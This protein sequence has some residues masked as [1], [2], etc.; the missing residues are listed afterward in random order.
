VTEDAV[1]RMRAKVDVSDRGRKLNV[2]DVQLLTND[3]AWDRPPGVLWI[4][5]GGTEL[6]NGGAARLKGL[7]SK[8]PGR[9][10]VHVKTQTAE[11]PKVVR[12]TGYTVDKSDG[13]LHAE[14]KEWLGAGAVREE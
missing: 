6:N 4:T 1:V 3:G 7:L 13:N 2:I 8:Y 5:A 11:G 14:L 10:A 12:L 9:D